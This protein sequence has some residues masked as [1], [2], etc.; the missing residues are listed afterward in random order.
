MPRTATCA[1]ST[2]SRRGAACRRPAAHRRRTGRSTPRW[3][4]SALGI[5]EDFGGLGCSFV[6][7]ALVAEE[8][9]RALALEPYIGCAVLAA[10]LVETADAPVFAAQR[11]GEL[12]E[13]MAGGALQIAL[14]HSEP[15]G[16]YELDAASTIARAEGERL[17]DRR[18]QADDARRAG[19]RTIFIVSARVDAARGSRCSWSTR[20]RPRCTAIR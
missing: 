1:S 18:H 3:A 4:G 12:L 7:T 14:A 11:R 15:A 19:A 5:P 17:R 20:A 8:L 13:A 2:A 16:R 10:R 9:G 6:E